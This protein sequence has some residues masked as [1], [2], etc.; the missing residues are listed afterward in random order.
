MH[1]KKIATAFAITI[2]LSGSAF[3]QSKSGKVPFDL[4]A[5][6][7]VLSKCR[8]HTTMDKELETGKFEGVQIKERFYV[9]DDGKRM[10]LASAKSGRDRTELRYNSNF[11]VMGEEKSY[12]ARLKIEKPILDSGKARLHFFQLHIKGFGKAKKGPLMTIHWI[13]E[14]NGNKDRIAFYTRQDFKPNKLT[15]KKWDL[16]PR[17]DDFFDLEVKIKEGQL[18]V[19]INGELKAEDD[20]SEFKVTKVYFKTGAY[21]KGIKPIKVEYESLSITAP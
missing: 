2:V 7:E 13:P 12:K 20:I 16:G 8:M 19:F 4:S 9:T 6:K 18:K 10:I 14:M 3:G 21:T 11:S 17:P 5:F 15:T 1:G